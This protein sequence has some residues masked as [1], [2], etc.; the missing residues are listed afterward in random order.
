MQG[1]IKNNFTQC[2]SKDKWFRAIE[3]AGLKIKHHQ[4]HIRALR[5]AIAIFEERFE[6][7]EPWPGSEK[8]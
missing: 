2:K 8:S 1:K 7:G 5:Q 3:D 6:S 4:R